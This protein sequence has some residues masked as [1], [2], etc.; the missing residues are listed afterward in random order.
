M[1]YQNP[2]AS[3]T[4]YGVVEIGGNIAVTDGVISIA[5]DVSPTANVTF[6][7]VN[8]TGNVIIN[9]NA[10]VSSV[11]P[12]A[13]N[14]ISI[15]SLTSTGPA[16]SFTVN[17]TGV[18]D[19]IAGTGITITPNSGLGNVTISANV[20]IIVSNTTAITANYTATAT[21]EYIGV[22]STNLVYITLP[23]GFNG[24]E[25]VIK[26]E[27]GPG[28]GKIKI[29]GTGG[30]TI[31]TQTTYPLNVPFSSATLIFRGSEWHVI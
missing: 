9:G 14:G 3:T 21:D 6:A 24:R 29:N 22:N 18:T 19:I 7:N 4:Q 8:V 25:Y 27:K 15:T 13:G 28:F 20:G 10:A 5:Q 2:Q 11:N 1:S 31:D 30:Q 17:N 12:T 16:V 26:D 23:T